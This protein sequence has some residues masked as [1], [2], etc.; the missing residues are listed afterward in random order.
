MPASLPD[1]CHFSLG[2]FEPALEAV[3][4]TQAIGESSADPRLRTFATS[5]T[6]WIYATRGD[7]EAGIEACQRA[8]QDSRDPSITAL[9]LDFLGHA[10]L[11]Q[12]DAARAIPV[13]ER[14]LEHF[15]RFRARHFQGRCMTSL[16]EAAL[17]NGHLEQARALAAQGLDIS[18]DVKYGYGIAYAQR[19]LGRVFRASGALAQAT[20]SLSE[21]LDT[22]TSIQARFEV[23]RTHLDL[24]AVAHAQGKREAVTRHL[25]EAHDLFSALQVPKYVERAAQLAHEFGVPPAE[26]GG[27]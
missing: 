2:E 24:A 12:G 3:A 1:R 27:C 5:S 10:Y 23:G 6:G 22:F 18:R 17:L 14:A 25:E 9:A 26:G 19:V 7:W 8:L 15:V 13:L 11:E 21:A 4:Q 20:T 16:S